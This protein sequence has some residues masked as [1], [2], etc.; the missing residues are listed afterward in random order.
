MGKPYS[1]IPKKRRKSRRTRACEIPKSVKVEVFARD[2]GLCIICGKPGIPNAHIIP[3]SAGGL[4]VKEN[5]VTLCPSC[6]HEFDNGKHKLRYAYKV[7]KYIKSQY[8]DWEEEKY[9]FKKWG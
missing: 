7:D 4:G 9:I 5:I 6:H 2:N 1:Y 8:E 3:R